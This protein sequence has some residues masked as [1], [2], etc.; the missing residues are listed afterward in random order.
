MQCLP[1]PFIICVIFS[2]CLQTLTLFSHRF[3]H[4]TITWS[5]GCI[6]DKGHY[7]L[8][9]SKLFQV[10][11]IRTSLVHL[12][13]NHPLLLLLA[14]TSDIGTDEK[15]TVLCLYWWR[16]FWQIQSWHHSFLERSLVYATA[17]SHRAV[18]WD[19][20]VTSPQRNLMCWTSI[21]AFSNSV[22][23]GLFQWQMSDLGWYNELLP[24]PLSRRVPQSLG[25]LLAIAVAEEDGTL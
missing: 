19:S 18:H 24:L 9:I 1:P 20:H 6:P 12:K 3:N 23:V 21:A 2:C 13:C 4:L 11:A 8:T 22:G 17:S 7:H 16:Y 15:R 5:S 25:Y 14:C 10:L